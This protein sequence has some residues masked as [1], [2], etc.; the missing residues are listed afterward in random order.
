MGRFAILAVVLWVFLICAGNPMAALLT[1]CID[2]NDHFYHQVID[3]DI[4]EIGNDRYFALA[5]VE[6]EDASRQNAFATCPVGCGLFPDSAVKIAKGK[7]RLCEGDSIF[8]YSDRCR[9]VKFKKESY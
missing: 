5:I 4:L 6:C 3:P 1:S 8:V 2:I 9:I 7:D